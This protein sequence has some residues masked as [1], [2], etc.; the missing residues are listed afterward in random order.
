[1]FQVIRKLQLVIK[2]CTDLCVDWCDLNPFVYPHIRCIWKEIEWFSRHRQGLRN[3]ASVLQTKPLKLELG[4]GSFQREGWIGIDIAGKPDL[5]LDLRRG[6]PFPDNSVD[7]IHSAHVFEHLEYPSELKFILSECYRVLKPGGTISF[8]VPNMRPYLEA[9]C[10]DNIG[11][12]KKYVFDRPTNRAYD[13]CA[14]D[15]INWFALRGG[16]HKFMFDD[17]NAKARLKEVG[18]VNVHI[19]DFDPSRDYNR[20]FSSVYV[21]G[22]KPS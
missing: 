12:L 16:E 8:S 20:R 1:M 18:F 19:R 2:I 6:L 13:A 14:M 5:Y 17:E 7:E 9:Y 21:E 10:A 15:I 3:L 22:K 11:F 4:C